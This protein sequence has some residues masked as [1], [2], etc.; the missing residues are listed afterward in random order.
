MSKE[1]M[2]CERQYSEEHHIVFRGQQPAMI[3]CPLNKIYL[4]YEHHRGDYS[5]HQKRI[6]DLKYK[7]ALQEWLE[8]IF[9]D[10][11]CYEE[12]EIKSLLLI[13]AKDARKLVKP[14]CTVI[15]EDEVGYKAEDIIRQCL[16][17]RLYK[18][19]E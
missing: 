19:C 11:E 9:G 6:V 18:G 2:E 7:V 13:P 3:N 10:K 16:G 14:L 15:V 4:C 8:C 12:D 5:P 1:C 17:G